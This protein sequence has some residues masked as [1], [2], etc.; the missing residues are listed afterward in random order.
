M[1]AFDLPVQC[2]CLAA[3]AVPLERQGPPADHDNHK[4]LPQALTCGST[5]FFLNMLLVNKHS[6]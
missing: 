3:A 5:I 4:L 2:G 1:L 6:A